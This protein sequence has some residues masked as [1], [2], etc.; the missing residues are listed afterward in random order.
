MILCLAAIGG[1]ILPPCGVVER[2][3]ETTAIGLG[4]AGGDGF[5][6]V[7]AVGAACCC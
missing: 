6:A 5:A 2:C 4:L 3:L 7:M 1:R